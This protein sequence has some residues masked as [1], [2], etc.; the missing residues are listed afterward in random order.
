MK[1]QGTQLYT[2]DPENGQVMDVGCVT[3]ISGITS[4]NSQNE[5]TCLHDTARR[6]EPGLQEPGQAAFSIYTDPQNATHLRLLELKQ[7]GVV[8]PW[9]VGWSDGVGIPPTAGPIDSEGTYTF[10]LPATRSWLTFEGFIQDFPFDF[11]LN[12]QVTSAITVQM[13]GPVVL[14]PSVS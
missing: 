2:I 11:A 3:S 9:A 1:T 6:Y 8:L 4:P 12:S 14:V 5:V 7:E 13:S 10:T